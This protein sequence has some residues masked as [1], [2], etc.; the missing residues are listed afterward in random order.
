MELNMI[1]GG[2]YWHERKQPLCL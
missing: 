1:T 2:C